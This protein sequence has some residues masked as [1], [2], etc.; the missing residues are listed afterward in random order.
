MVTVLVVSLIDQRD[1]LIAR[2]LKE[3]G[4]ESVLKLNTQVADELL[5]RFDVAVL[6]GRPFRLTK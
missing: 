5:A 1:H 2:S 4:V 6:G 3:V